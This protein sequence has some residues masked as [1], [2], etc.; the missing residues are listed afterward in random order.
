MLPQYLLDEFLDIPPGT[1]DENAW[2]GA[3]NALLTEY[4]SV[5]E[6]WLARPPRSTRE[7]VDFGI[8]FKI[9]HQRIPAMVVEIKPYSAF[10]QLSARG[11][12]DSQMRRRFAEFYDATPSYFTGISAFGHIVCKYELNKED[13][14]RITPAA[15]PGSLERLV[16]VA[17]RMN[18]DLDLTTDG[19]ATR[20]LHIFQEVKDVMLNEAVHV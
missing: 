15:I 3:W 4:F 19:G 11:D 18:W 6:G 20:I 1:T 13:N 12:A 14:N 9:E 5:K 8:Y 2:S 10:D 16:D 17:P 7:A